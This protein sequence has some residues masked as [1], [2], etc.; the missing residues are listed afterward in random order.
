MHTGRRTGTAS[1]FGR[2]E[3]NPPARCRAPVLMRHHMLGFMI[4]SFND[5]YRNVHVPQVSIHR[6]VRTKMVT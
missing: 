2:P 3:M 1:R 4:A 5:P 6:L